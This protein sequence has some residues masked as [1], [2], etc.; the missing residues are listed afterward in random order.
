M[1]RSLGRKSPESL[2]DVL[3]WLAAAPEG[4]SLSAAAVRELLEPLAAGL[5]APVSTPSTPGVETWRERLWTVPA[6][7]RLGVREVAEAT[8]RPRSWIY[9]RTSAASEKAPLPHRKLDGELV[10]VAGE[11][12]AWL[13]RHEIPCA[14]NG[15]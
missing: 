11:L 14:G 12:R 15:A 8:G 7:T 2:S 1:G 6:D 13:K 10:F 4:T 5:P 3:V 9:R